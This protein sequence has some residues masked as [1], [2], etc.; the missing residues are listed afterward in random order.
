MNKDK[1][2]EEILRIIRKSCEPVSGTKLAGMLGVS[3]QIVVQDIEMLRQDNKDIISTSQGYLANRTEKEFKRI[4]KVRHADD[5]IENELNCIV[6][7][8]GIILDVFV[9]HDVYGE[10]RTALCLSNRMD[11]KRFLENFEN[12]K[13]SPLKKLTQDIHYHTVVAKSEE[14]LDTI[15]EELRDNHFLAT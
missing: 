4:F 11:V 9:R 14:M 6:D 12:E 13:S 7:A 1:R 15:E 10:I 5:Q 2:R 3:R 8:G